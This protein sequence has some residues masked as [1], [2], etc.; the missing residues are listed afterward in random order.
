MAT[1]RQ[2][3]GGRT[4]F[5]HREHVFL[6]RDC[7]EIDEV[8]GYEVTRTRVFFDDVLLVTRHR[9]VPGST[10]ALATL[11]AL[12]FGLM[13]LGVGAGSG[14]RWGI[15]TFVL[16]GAPLLT[17]AVVLAVRGAEAVTVQGRRTNA[18]MHFGLRQRRARD[19][20]RRACRLVRESQARLARQ[21]GAPPPA[22]PPAPPSPEPGP[23]S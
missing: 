19:V 20:Y 9:F 4:A 15:L 12:M 16:T 5:S 23:A 3:L 11:L 21:R 8:E 7:F 13:A 17:Y 22:A 1:K 14:A 6:A 2:K 10:V 18:R